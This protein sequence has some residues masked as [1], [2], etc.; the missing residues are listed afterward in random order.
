MGEKGVFRSTLTADGAAGHASLPSDRRQRPAEARPAAR[1]ARRAPPRLGRDARRRA[2]LAALGLEADGDPAARRGRAARAGARLR[3]ARSRR[4][5][6]VTLAPTM[7]DASDQ[8]NVIPAAARLHVDCPGAARH[9]GAHGAERVREVLG[10][11]RLPARVHRVRRRQLLAARV[12]AARRARRLGR[13]HRAGRALPAD[14]LGRLLGL[15]RLP[16]APSPTASPTA[17]SPPAH[18]GRAA[19]RARPRRATS[20]STC[21]TSRWR[22][23]ATATSRPSC[24]ADPPSSPNASAISS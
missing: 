17:S 13:A 24:S 18:D 23:T 2:L 22:S 5:C 8:M 7:V 9:G 21:A 6:G 20:A 10:D 16:R 19:R 12:A 14:D 4:C 15:A 1:G 3:A 11:S